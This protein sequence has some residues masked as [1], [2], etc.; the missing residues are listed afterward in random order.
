M[1][2]PALSPSCHTL[3]YHYS[4]Y[5]VAA[6]KIILSE[7]HVVELWAEGCWASTKRNKRDLK[8]KFGREEAINIIKN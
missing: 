7:M 1:V 3:V 4:G 2:S 8:E 6:L 5:T